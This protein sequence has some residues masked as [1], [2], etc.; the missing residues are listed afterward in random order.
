MQEGCYVGWEG[1]VKSSRSQPIRPCWEAWHR[2]MHQQR[3]GQ[4]QH[5]IVVQPQGWIVSLQGSVMVGLGEAGGQQQAVQQVRCHSLQQ[6]CTLI[7]SLRQGTICLGSGVSV[8]CTV[9]AC[10]SCQAGEHTVGR[11]HS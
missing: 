8:E 6:G 7:V 11:V 5:Q 10:H 4:Q 1:R 2:A 3:E 9:Y